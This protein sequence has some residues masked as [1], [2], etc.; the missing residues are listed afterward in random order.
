MVAFAARSRGKVV[1]S[2]GLVDEL[3]DDEML[4]V[5]HEAAQIRKRGYRLR[6]RGHLQFAHVADVSE[7]G[8]H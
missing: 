3:S 1:P 6:K 4:V 8:S 7:S 5:R 2:E